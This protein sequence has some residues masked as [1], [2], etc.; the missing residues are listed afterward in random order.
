M[1]RKGGPG[2]EIAEQHKKGGPFDER[3]VVEQTHDPVQGLPRRTVTPAPVGHIKKFCQFKGCDKPAVGSVPLE[4]TEVNACEDHM[5]KPYL[6]SLPKTP[7][8]LAEVVPE[9]EDL[10]RR[11]R[12]FPP[13]KGKDRAARTTAIRVAIIVKGMV[14]SWKAERNYTRKSVEFLQGTRSEPSETKLLF[15]GPDESGTVL[16]RD[17]EA[18]GIAPESKMDDVLNGLMAEGWRVVFRSFES[19]HIMRQW[20]VVLERS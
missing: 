1:E 19:S 2:D 12:D 11:M 13:S 17:M 15:F 16:S 20:R 3:P 7:D 10:A 9:L 18:Q 4:G 8:S 5:D 6:A 14:E